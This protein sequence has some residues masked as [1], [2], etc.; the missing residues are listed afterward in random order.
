MRLLAALIT[1]AVLSLLCGRVTTAEPVRIVVEDADGST[2]A[3]VPEQAPPPDP[4][5]QRINWGINLADV[6][7]YSTE[8]PFTDLTKQASTWQWCLSSGGWNNAPQGPTDANGWPTAVAPGTYAALVLDMHDGLP[9]TTYEVTPTA[10]VTVDGSLDGSFNW[11][12]RVLVRVRSGIQTLSMHERGVDTSQL[13]WPPFVERC[14]KF[15]CLRFM[16]WAQVNDSRQVSWAN[17]VTPSYYT[18]GDRE[19]AYELQLRLAVLCDADAWINVHHTASDDYVRSLARL[20]KAE[21]P[22]RRKLYVEHSN[23]VWNA[24][25]PAYRYCVERSPKTRSPLEY[26]ITRTA[27]IAAILREEGVDV[28]SVLGAQS[29]AAGHLQWV[30]GQTGQSLDSIDAVAIAP[31]FGHSVTYGA[32]VSGKDAILAQCEAEIDTIR[33]QI[34]QYKALC[35]Q[36]QV[37]LVAYEGGQHVLASPQEQANQAIVNNIIEAN[38]DPRMGECYKRYMKLWDEATNKAPFCL[39]NSVYPPS[40]HGCW[41]LQEYEGQT[42]AVKYRAVMDYMGISP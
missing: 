13:F 17:R 18:Q 38:R 8:R 11:T 10:G 16:N 20:C 1:S 33:T 21:W 31:Y 9:R 36:Y 27:R 4:I 19:V 34:D 7:Y 25:F 24:I 14:K 3:F 39:F 35:A 42:S 12:R 41:G 15:G 29:V 23:E 32:K 22:G 30:L 5:P 37:Q 40:K 2:R 26:H 28:V 6:R